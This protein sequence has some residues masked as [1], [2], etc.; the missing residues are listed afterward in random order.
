MQSGSMIPDGVCQREDGKWYARN[1]VGGHSLTRGP[2][3]A[4][5]EAEAAYADAD[6]RLSREG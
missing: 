4:Q 3:E 5:A 2:Y 6:S 1:F